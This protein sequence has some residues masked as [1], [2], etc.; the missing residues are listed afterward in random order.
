MSRT[1]HQETGFPRS[2]CLQ[3]YF[4]GEVVNK[5]V[6]R[7]GAIGTV[8]SPKYRTA[9]IEH[10]SKNCIERVNPSIYSRRQFWPPNFFLAARLG[11]TCVTLL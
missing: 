11:A 3:K 4:W 5:G 6:A 8:A 1:E 9:I 7:G 10:L 2:G